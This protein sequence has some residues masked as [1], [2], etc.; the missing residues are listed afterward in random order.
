MG[1]TDSCTIRKGFGYRRIPPPNLPNKG[2]G[3]GLVRLE[4]ATR[5]KHP[6]LDGEGWGGVAR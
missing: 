6:P 3:A 4:T 2:G 5:R 1:S